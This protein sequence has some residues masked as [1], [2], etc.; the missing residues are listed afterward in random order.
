[1][2]NII[3]KDEIVAYQETP[4]YVRKHENGSYVNTDKQHAEFIADKGNLYPIN[5][6]F[7]SEVDM[8]TKMKDFTL[9]GIDIID[10]Q[11]MIVNQAVELS[12]LSLGITE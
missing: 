9:Q 1:M 7:I 3:H 12:M 10:L 8:G 2:Y 11:E 6:T 5:E 4:N